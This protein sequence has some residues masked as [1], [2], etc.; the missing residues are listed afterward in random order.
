MSALRNGLL[1]CGE[2]FEEQDEF[3]LVLGIEREK[4]QCGFRGF[5][6]M[7]GDGFFERDRPA[8]VEVR[9]GIPDAPQRRRSLRTVRAGLPHTALRLMVL[10]L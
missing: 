8:I 7:H 9:S 1:R 4:L 10:P 6:V 5:A 2:R 3:L